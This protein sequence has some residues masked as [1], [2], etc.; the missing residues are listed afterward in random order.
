LKN[1]AH[2][3]LFRFDENIFL[4]R[5]EAFVAEI[6]GAAVWFFQTADHP[7]GRC[8]TAAARAEQGKELTLSNLEI[9]VVDRSD[10]VEGFKQALNTQKTHFVA[11]CTQIE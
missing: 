2:I 11:L 5:Y 7:Q 10:S 4:H 3:A 8:F 6:N 1:H 9:D